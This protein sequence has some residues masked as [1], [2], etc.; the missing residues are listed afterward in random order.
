MAVCISLGRFLALEILT[1]A[2]VLGA[3]DLARKDENGANEF[4]MISYWRSLEDVHNFAYGPTH[5]EAWKWWY[6]TLKEHSHIGIMHELY[7]AEKGLWE[8][9]YANFQPT[10]LGRTTY[11]KR[12]G[13]IVGGEVQDEWINPLVGANNTVLRWSNRRRGV[14]ERKEI[15]DEMYANNPYEM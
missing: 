8:S 13:K 1:F 5:R 14:G 15:L 12:D 10:L 7:E 3:T 2:L 11:L 6:R 9:I 4:I